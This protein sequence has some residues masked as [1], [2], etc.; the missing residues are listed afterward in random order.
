MSQFVVCA[1]YT[2]NYEEDVRRLE[3][4]LKAFGHEYYLK[5]CERLPT[6]E[7]N[8]GIKPGFLLECLQR[9]PDKDVLYIDADAFVRRELEGFEQ[10]DG[11]IGIHFNENG[12]SHQIRTGTIYLRNNERTLSFLQDWTAAQQADVKFNDQD[13]FEVVLAKKPEVSFF[14][15]PVAFVKIY[16]RAGDDVAPYI[17]H[18][19]SSRL[20]ENIKIRDGK[21]RKRKKYR[22]LLIITNLVYLAIIAALVL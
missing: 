1:F 22:R 4:S 6:W 7:Q 19:Q 8:T 3:I 9:F 12:G 10:F 5:P 20:T 14:Q 21:A 17:E 18:F 13:S 16:D 15:L 2:P 11:D